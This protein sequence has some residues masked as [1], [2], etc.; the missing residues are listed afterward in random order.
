MESM[1][2]YEDWQG[3][4]WEFTKSRSGWHFNTGMPPRLGHDSYTPVCRFVADFSDAISECLPRA[5]PSSWS[6]R[7]DFNADIARQGLYSATAEENDLI[8]AGADPKQEIFS[9]A[10]AEDI[11]LFR[12]ISDE[13]GLTD[14]MI[15]FHNQTTGQMLHFHIDNFA[16]RPERENSFRSTDFDHDP[17]RM[18]RFAIM[19][20]DWEMGQA[21]M[22]GNAIY[23]RWRAG[24]C[25]TWEWRDMPHA[26]VNAGWANRPLLQITGRVTDKTDALIE[27]AE[28]SMDG[29]GHP[30]VEVAL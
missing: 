16:A 15:K 26:T 13:L 21:W 24:D 2:G 17:S 28:R 23:H 1:Q 3:S 25:I 8:R 11:P 10:A 12:R 4:R 22:F 27:A 18:R 9:R 19:L 20:A 14:S 5:R 7:N 29:S 6:S 30:T